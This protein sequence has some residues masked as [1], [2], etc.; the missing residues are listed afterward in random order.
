MTIAAAFVCH[1]GVVL[2]ADTEVTRSPFSKTN[3]SKI[4]GIHNNVDVYLTYCGGVDYV[5]ELIER[6]RD[7]SGIT[8]NPVDVKLSPDECFELIRNFYQTDMAA[9]L[10]KPAESVMWTE[11]LVAV[12]RSMHHLHKAEY[13]YRTTVYH[14]NG[15]SV[16]PVDR[17]AAI[18]I[19]A[20]IAHAVFGPIYQGHVGVLESS[21]NMVY[22]LRRVK[23]TVPGC[24][25]N[26]T[27]MTIANAGDYPVDLIPSAEL[28]QIEDDCEFLDNKLR[29]LYQWV[30]SSLTEEGFEHNF[31]VLK[32]RIIE[33]RSQPNRLNFPWKS[34]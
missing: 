32:K 19:G 31:E 27:V 8:Y 15:G 18:G 6:V 9:E 34:S 10:Q 17:Y 24:G 20:D 22:A 28:K 4:H 2:G 12:R 30:P 3:E 21:F 33:R 25:G 5:R 29:M 1:N 7:A 23:A 11:L 13:E 16:V 26:S 14:L